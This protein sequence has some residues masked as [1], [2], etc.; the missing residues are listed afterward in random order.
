MGP[1]IKSKNNTTKMMINVIISLIPII[2]FGIIKNA[3]NKETN[4]IYPLIFVLI[5]VLTSF[6][7]ETLYSVIIQ[8]KKNIKN[9]I[10]N[11]Y[12]IMTGLIMTLIIPINTSIPI[13]ILATTLSSI[14]GKMI[15]GGF[16][17]NKINPELIGY[18]LV[19]ILSYLKIIET[20]ETIL[21]K[22]HFTLILLALIFLTLTKTIKWRL[23]LTYILTIFAINYVIGGIGI[24]YPIKEIISTSILFGSVY[25][26]TEQTSTPVTPIGQILFGMFA[27]IITVIIRHITPIPELVLLSILIMNPLTKTLDKI[28]ALARFNFKEALIPFIIAWI[29]IL[30]L[31]IGLTLTKK[32]EITEIDTPETIIEEPTT[33]EENY[34]LEL[35]NNVLYVNIKDG[36]ITSIT[37]QEENEEMTNYINIILENQDNLEQIENI[38]EILKEKIITIKQ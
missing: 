2:V 31:S 9:I 8:K 1:F 26:I 38:P 5:A 20:N 3:I 10:K 25:I 37:Q 14:F 30:L 28:G 17:K 32:T 18:T 22:S 21:G 15:F 27:G 6:T 36:L 35:E 33:K 4:I 7:V 13:L 24:L 34:T 12:S 16:G 23:S 11:N 19:Y 29:M